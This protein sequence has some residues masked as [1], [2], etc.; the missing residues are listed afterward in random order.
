MYL[1]GSGAYKD[2]VSGAYIILNE[3]LT[4]VYY[5]FLSL[6]YISN[7][8]LNAKEIAS[9]CIKI[10]LAALALNVLTSAVLFVLKII[11][12]IRNYKEKRKN[13]IIQIPITE[14]SNDNDEVQSFSN[15]K[16]IKVISNAV[17]RNSNKRIN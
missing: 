2:K 5:V 8:D 7:L 15:L 14:V 17:M 10:L 6:P 16:N 1:W 11:N 3:L 4:C 13:R 9:Y 12:C